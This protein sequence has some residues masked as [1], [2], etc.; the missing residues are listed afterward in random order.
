MQHTAHST[1][2]RL[3][4]KRA[5]NVR[6]SPFLF[7]K[8]SDRLLWLL[9]WTR[10]LSGW[11]LNLFQDSVLGKGLHSLHYQRACYAIV[12]YVHT[13]AYFPYFYSTL[14][15]RKF[16][17]VNLNDTSCFCFVSSMAVKFAGLDA[18]LVQNKTANSAVTLNNLK[19]CC[20]EFTCLSS[21]WQLAQR[22]IS[23]HRCY[24]RWLFLWVKI[25]QSHNSESFAWWRF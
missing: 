1:R 5:S 9:L 16:H 6:N 19:A 13:N 22:E 25:S 12:I 17:C 14:A 8:W 3:H 2:K 4:C 20:G 18:G 21:W 7:S 24:G 10:R 11:Q 15:T 23:L